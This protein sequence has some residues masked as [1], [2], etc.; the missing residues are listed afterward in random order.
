MKEEVKKYFTE[1]KENLI[2]TVTL[3]SLEKKTLK[4]IDHLRSEYNTVTPI[5]KNKLEKCFNL[6]NLRNLLLENGN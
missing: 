1:L 2:E 4:I 5:M 6:E 3:D